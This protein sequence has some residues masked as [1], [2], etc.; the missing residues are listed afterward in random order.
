MVVSLLGS[1]DHPERINAEDA[2]NIT[3]KKL[4]DAQ[5][6][7]RAWYRVKASRELFAG[8]RIDPTLSAN[9]QAY[10]AISER[11]YRVIRQHL[12]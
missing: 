11:T 2:A 7:S 8:Q 12:P 5:P 10:T 6:H 9:M 4:Q 3:V 1:L